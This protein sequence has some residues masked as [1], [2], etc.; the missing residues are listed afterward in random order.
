MKVG[1]IGAGKVGLSVAK[2][3]FNH[4]NTAFQLTGF[5]SR[6]EASSSYASEVTQ[7]KQFFK[8]EQCVLENDL[9]FITTPDDAFSKIW[10]N[11]L[12]MRIEN[13]FFVHCSGSLASDVFTKKENV[14][15]FTASLHPLLAVNDKDNSYKQFQ[16]TFFTLEG[17][18]NAVQLLESLLQQQNNK[19]KIINKD[20]KTKYHL[21][22]VCFSN[23]MLSL[24]DVAVQLL[25]EC[26]FNEQEALATFENLA[27]N[28][29]NNFF[30]KGAIK[31]LTGPIERGDITTVKRHLITIQDDEEK[32]LIYKSLS[33]N[34]VKIAEQKNNAIDYKQ[35][36]E[37]LIRS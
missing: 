36:K 28:N 19:Y 27:K 5:Y 37:L 6:S 23:L 17:D 3:F 35:L 7:T 11:I 9:L 16:N 2:Y 1:I 22:A 10:E 30:E 18:N 33:N 24:G 31:S 14:V 12:Q 13:K 4:S 34:L 29:I 15:F 26:G 25:L 20:D 32:K 21:A 8:L